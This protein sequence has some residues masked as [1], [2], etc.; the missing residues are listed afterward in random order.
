M[1][2]RKTAKISLA[3]Q[4]NGGKTSILAKIDD[5][6][7]VKATIGAAFIQKSYT[8]DNCIVKLEIWD[9][10]GQERF[11]AISSIYF[12]HSTHCILVFDL[13][14]ADSFAKI[15][16]WKQLCDKS[17]TSTPTYYLV[18]NKLDLGK[19]ATSAE[20]IQNYCSTNN[21]NRYFETSAF[22]GVGIPE[23]VN[24]LISSVTECEQVLI[25]SINTTVVLTS[26]V[27]NTSY[28]SC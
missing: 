22:T 27:T 11:N 14:D 28:C 4:S 10:A 7:D 9:T 2:E 3:G 13:S 1:I 21:I 8:T 23:L 5:R 19:R 12:R 6:V 15:D 25:P 20:T 24:T 26:E 17:S 18:G 16:S